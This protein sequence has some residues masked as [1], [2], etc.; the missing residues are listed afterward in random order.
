[1]FAP[2]VCTPPIC[3][4]QTHTHM[5][6]NH[7]HTHNRA[8]IH[9]VVVFCTNGG[10]FCCCFYCNK[11]EQIKKKTTW[12]ASVCVC[13]CQY[14]SFVSLRVNDDEQRGMKTEAHERVLHTVKNIGSA[15]AQ[16]SSKRRW[17]WMQMWTWCASK[18]LYISAALTWTD[19]KVI[20]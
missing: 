7:A 18:L 9:S 15:P 2:G 1:M 17:L 13:V 6:T 19:N 4:T 10:F 11:K 3:G 20:R 12:D 8:V 5:H 16:Q 14:H